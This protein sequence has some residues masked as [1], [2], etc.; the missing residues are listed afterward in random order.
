MEKLAA[1]RSACMEEVEVGWGG[2]GDRPTEDEGERERERAVYLKT[3]EISLLKLVN[4]F[5]YEISAAVQP[6]R[7]NPKKE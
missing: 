6:S 7:E 2:W 5:L 4:V 1:T 3:K